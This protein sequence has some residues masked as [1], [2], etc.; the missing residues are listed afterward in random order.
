MLR[1]LGLRDMMMSVGIMIGT[2]L[3]VGTILRVLLIG[4]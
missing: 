1:E 4:V 2:V 3:V